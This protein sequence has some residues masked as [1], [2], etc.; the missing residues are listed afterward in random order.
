MSILSH[1]LTSLPASVSLLQV[2]NSGSARCWA[3]EVYNP[4]PGVIDDKSLPSNN[5]YKPGG[6]RANPSALLMPDMLAVLT[7]TVACKLAT[8]PSIIAFTPSSS[9]LGVPWASH[10]LSQTSSLVVAVVQV[11]QPAPSTST[12]ACC[13]TLHRPLRALRPWHATSWSC[14]TS[15]C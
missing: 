10:G 4:V 11:C 3:S 12:W 5:G 7:A 1:L 6:F 14:T 15:E 2:L 13:W 9:C 8:A